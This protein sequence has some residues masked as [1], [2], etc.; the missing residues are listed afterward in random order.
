MRRYGVESLIDSGKDSI[1][2]L[3]APDDAVFAI[4]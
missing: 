4:S 3:R 1:R 2:G